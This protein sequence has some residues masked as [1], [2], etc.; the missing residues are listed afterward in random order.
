VFEFANARPHC[1]TFR[2]GKN[3]TALRNIAAHIAVT[4]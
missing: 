2:S 4:H 1:F 3:G